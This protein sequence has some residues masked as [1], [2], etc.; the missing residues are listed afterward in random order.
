VRLIHDGRRPEA[1]RS[2]RLARADRGMISTCQRARRGMIARI[3]TYVI[4]A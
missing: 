1:K 3:S 4:A 2:S